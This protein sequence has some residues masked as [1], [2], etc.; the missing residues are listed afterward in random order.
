MCHSLFH[1]LIC[2]VTGFKIS[3]EKQNTA[4]A[5]AICIPASPVSNIRAAKAYDLAIWWETWKHNIAAYYRRLN[6]SSSVFLVCGMRTT[7]Q[8]ANCCHSDRDMSTELRI[9][10]SAPL[11]NGTFSIGAR[12][13]EVNRTF[14]FQIGEYQPQSMP[15]VIFVNKLPA[16]FWGP[17]RRL[18]TTLLNKFK[19]ACSLFNPL[20]EVK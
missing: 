17:M 13:E 19:Y 9:S 14:G 6:T 20:I 4:S 18:K 1:N 12:I 10:G 2:R 15:W 3:I 11:L 16:C 7:A 5:A 8:Y